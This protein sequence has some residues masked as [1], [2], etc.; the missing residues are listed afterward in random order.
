MRR[1][2]LIWAVAAL[3]IAAPASALTPRESLI[4]AVFDA[5]DKAGALAMIDTADKAASAVLA[6][7]P[8]DREA[9]L[10]RAMALGYRAKIG[11]SRHDALA[12]RAQLEALAAADPRDAEAQIA[13]AGWHLDAIADVGAFMARAALGADRR[14]GLAALDRAIA[15]EPNRAGFPA[16]ASMMRIRLDPADVSRAR[17]LAEAAVLAAAPTSLDIALRRRIGPLLAPLRAGDGKRAAAVA[18]TLLPLGRLR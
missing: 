1:E 12:A 16:L 3:V 14:T 8:R 13:V 2:R 5:R 9:T 18:R 4:V 15:L 11:R 6:R 10:I 17:Q 7:A